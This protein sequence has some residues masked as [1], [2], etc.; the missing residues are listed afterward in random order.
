MNVSCARYRVP[1]HLF[2]AFCLTLL[3]SVFSVFPAIA[4]N[5]DTPHPALKDGQI[6]LIRHAYAPGGGD[7]DNFTLGQCATQRNLNE[8]GREQARHIGQWFRNQSVAVAQ[9]LSSQWCR[10]ME[11]A[12]LAFPNQVTDAPEF[13]SFFSNRQTEA[14]Q[15]QRALV[16][17]ARWD[18][19]GLMVVV[20]HQVN[21]TA[22]TGIVPK[23]GEGIVVEY[24]NGAVQVVE[25]LDFGFH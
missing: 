19:P 1:M 16:R 21:I 20:T 14:M 5:A 6:V 13:N 11:T 9:V 8:T 22:L 15:T 17:F 4:Q 3:L 23:S 25:R 2:N 18:G 10:C 7:P 12:T 24:K